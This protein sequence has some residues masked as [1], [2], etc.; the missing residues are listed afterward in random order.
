MR[1][2]MDRHLGRQAV[3][4]E[5][6]RARHNASLVLGCPPQILALMQYLDTLGFY[7]RL[8]DEQG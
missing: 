4:G 7:V 2:N 1:S 8:G 6:K 3:I 5:M